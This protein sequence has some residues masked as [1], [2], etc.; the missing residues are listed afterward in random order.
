MDS[1]SRPVGASLSTMVHEITD[2]LQAH[3]DESTTQSSSGV[4]NTR[5]R[6][7]LVALLSECLEFRIG[8]RLPCFCCRDQQNWSEATHYRRQGEGSGYGA[9]ARHCRSAKV[10]VHDQW[11]QL[12]R[13][14]DHATE[15]HSHVCPGQV[16]V[17]TFCTVH[18]CLPCIQC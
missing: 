17:K 13:S 5:M 1:A 8:Q 15:N 3:S 14:S 12:L 6:T 7:L 18:S 4:L 10:P 9:Q 16:Q 2:Y 11:G